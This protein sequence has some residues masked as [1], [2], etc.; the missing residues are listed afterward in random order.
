M[1]LSWIKL[2]S[3]AKKTYPRVTADKQIENEKCGNC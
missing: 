3:K 1:V 2:D